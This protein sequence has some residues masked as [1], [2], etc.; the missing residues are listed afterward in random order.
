MSR[1]ASGKPSTKAPP[2]YENEVFAVLAYEFPSSDQAVSDRRIK[3]RLSRKKLG[4]FDPERV[5][6]MRRLK[7][8]LQAEI[9]KSRHSR[10]Y[11]HTGGDYAE[12]SDF[13]LAALS[14]D[15]IAR[16]PEIPAAEIESF[17]AFSVFINHLL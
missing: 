10:Y 3:G 17:V 11:T 1:S 6:R 16:Y 15:S 12:M 9:G 4:R 7:D 8:E 14:R 13:D 2:T 5:A